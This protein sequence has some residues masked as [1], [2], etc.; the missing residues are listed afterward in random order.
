[1]KAIIFDMDGVLLDSERLIKDQFL[2][3]TNSKGYKI[4]DD[5]YLKMVGR[6][7]KDS[8]KIME[9]LVDPKFQWVEI[10]EEIK[11]KINED[12]KLNGWPLRPYVIE[13]LEKLKLLNIPITIATSTQK[14]E[15]ISRLI[16]ADIKKY[17][18]IISGGNEVN[19]GK[20]APDL[21]LLASQRIGVIPEECVVIEDSEYGIIAANEANMKSVLVPDLKTP[22]AETSQMTLGVFNDLGSAVEFLL[23]NMERRAPARLLESP[24]RS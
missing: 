15:A 24:Q 1:M 13:S 4:S 17:F 14:E 11:V 21:F 2:R 22:S 18:E 9:E 20:P 7:E 5:T 6:N 10:K 8:K 12:T 16:S 3:I 23:K 19:R